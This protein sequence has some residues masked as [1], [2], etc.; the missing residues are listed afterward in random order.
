MVNFGDGK[1]IINDRVYF[2]KVIESTELML[3][4]TDGI[5]PYFGFGWSTGFDREKGFSISGDI[6]FYYA[7]NFDIEFSANCTKYVSQLNALG[8]KEMQKRRS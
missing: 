6:G 3:Q 1:F 4:L 2:D 8:L 7:I 5:S